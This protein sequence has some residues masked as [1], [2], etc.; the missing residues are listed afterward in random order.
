M[1]F[2]YELNKQKDPI[3]I[4]IINM[5]ENEG[6]TKKIIKGEW[7]NER[8]KYRKRELERVL[9]LNTFNLGG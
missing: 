4:W 3:Q 1:S 9:F 6:P 7:K 2:I 5:R 8:L